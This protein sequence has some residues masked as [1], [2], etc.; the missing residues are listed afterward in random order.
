MVT[1]VG[2]APKTMNTHLHVLEAYT[3]LYGFGPIRF[4]NRLRNL[5]EIFLD[6][7]IDRHRWHQ[8]LFL[9]MTWENLD[10]IDSYGHDIELSWLIYEAAMALK[11]LR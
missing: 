5:I 1:T 7:I 4:E 8:R 3:L 11:M 9:T 10:E 2:I 6:K